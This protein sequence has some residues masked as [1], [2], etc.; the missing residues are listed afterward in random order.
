MKRWTSIHDMDGRP[1]QSQDLD[2]QDPLEIPG[3]RRGLVRWGLFSAVDDS[4]MMI[5]SH[6]SLRKCDDS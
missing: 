2:G 6:Y 3:G 5:T 1:E 4:R